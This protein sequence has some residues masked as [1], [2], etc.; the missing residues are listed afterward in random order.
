MTAFDALAEHYD[1]DTFHN[2]VVHRMINGVPEG[3]ARV[4]DA[5]TGTGH[6]AFEAVRA[7]R[8]RTV[9]AIDLSRKMIAAARAKAATLDPAGLITWHVGDAVPAPVPDASVDLVLCASA[10]HFLGGRAL[11]D[12]HRVLRPGGIV[13]FSLPAHRQSAT[14]A[15]ALPRNATEAAAV[16]AAFTDVTVTEVHREERHQYV[17][18]ARK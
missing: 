16:A 8:P 17:I 7:L 10:L 15:L 4:L 6:A 12:W 2:D 3:V 5:G 13:T 18:H 14:F 9:T 1:E 11:P